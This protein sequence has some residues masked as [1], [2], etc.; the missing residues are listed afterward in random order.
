MGMAFVNLCY[1]CKEKK[2][3]IAML[4]QWRRI[5]IF[6]EEKKDFGV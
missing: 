3:G 4:S 5:R 2:K 6:L 1:M